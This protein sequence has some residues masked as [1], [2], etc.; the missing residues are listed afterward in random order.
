MRKINFF[1]EAIKRIGRAAIKGSFGFFTHVAAYSE[2]MWTTFKR[3]PLFVY[4][5]DL[6]VSQ[7]YLL[8]IESV[9]LVTVI[10]IFLGSVTV[11]Q[12]IYQMSGIIPMRYL[13][14]LVCKGITNELAPA[15]T[16]M[17]FAGRVATGIAAEIAYMKNSEQ[18]DAMT[19]L[20]LDPIRYL[21][22]PRTL[23]CI[24]MVP[25]LVIWS[26][27]VAILGALVTV[28]ISVDI[29]IHTFLRGLR[30]FFNEYDLYFGVLK[31]TVFGLIVAITGSHFGF[32]ARSGA[33]GV[34]EATTKAVVTSVILILIFDFLMALLVF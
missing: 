29:T 14:V 21:I 16:S 3:T 25:V 33:E 5:P 2:L 18:F 34:G 22:V 28:I 8:G 23:A 20:G 15:I 30:L 31:T 17:V 27:L 19:V 26:E 12:A 6:T 1:S 13:G 9:G 11:T 10:A 24:V 4:N 32:T 7:M